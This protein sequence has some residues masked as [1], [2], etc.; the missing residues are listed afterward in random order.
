MNTH[1]INLINQNITL[2]K[3]FLNIK[4]VKNISTEQ[5]HRIL[6]IVNN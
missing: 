5:S 1:K 2:Q 4:G 6:K 3:A